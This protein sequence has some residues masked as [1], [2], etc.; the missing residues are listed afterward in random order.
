MTS[1]DTDTAKNVTDVLIRKLCRDF[2]LTHEGLW[3]HADLGM[4]EDTDTV[5]TNTPDI[6]RLNRLT[7]VIYSVY[8]LGTPQA[9]TPPSGP[10]GPILTVFD[11]ENP[12]FSNALRQAVPDNGYRD[13]GWRI[14][15]RTPEENGMVVEKKGVYLLVPDASSTAQK[16]GTV[17]IDM[18][19]YR[20][21]AIPGFFMAWGA[22]GPC[23]R[24]AAMDRLYIN[25]DSRHAPDFVRLLCLWA[26]SH[27][28]AMTLKAVNAP[29]HYGRPDT[30]VSYWPRD[31]WRPL[32]HTLLTTLKQSGLPMRQSVPA[33]TARLGPGLAWAEGIANDKDS[34][35]NSGP[36]VASF[37]KHRCTQI[38]KGLETA[39]K[40]GDRTPEGRYRVVADAWAK[41][42]ISFQHPHLSPRRT[43]T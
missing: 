18:P 6:A 27:D 1:P 17:A 41:A 32:R 37:G 25:S 24:G 3:Q 23:P 4:I 30:I 13:P 15:D 43:G 33:F 34:K 29:D 16:D 40:T 35:G 26:D 5:D 10:T 36:D 31:V 22:S 11:R 2:S 8:Y 9:V 38:A 28:M 20:P 42:G 12:S 39:R 21:Y 14:V 7:N 19:R